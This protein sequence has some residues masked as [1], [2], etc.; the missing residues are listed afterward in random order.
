MC[1]HMGRRAK[2]RQGDGK[3]GNQPGGQVNK[4]ADFT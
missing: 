1:M 4:K 3:A 2:A